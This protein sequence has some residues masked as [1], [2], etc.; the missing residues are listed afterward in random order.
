ML[1]RWWRAQRQ[2]AAATPTA[3]S[4]VLQQQP[5][6]QLRRRL[7]ITFLEVAFF[8]Y[9]SLLTSTLVLFACF[10]ID[11]PASAGYQNAL[12]SGECLLLDVISFVGVSYL[13]RHSLQTDQQFMQCSNWSCFCLPACLPACLAACLPAC[14]PE[15]CSRATNSNSCLFIPGLSLVVQS[16]GMAQQLVV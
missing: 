8:Y 1:S 3:A 2:S 13:Q 7:L 14:L 9:P 10:P 6:A 15:S 16:H 12:V 4:A 5:S 11:P